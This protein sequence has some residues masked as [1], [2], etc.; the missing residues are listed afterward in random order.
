MKSGPS[1][2]RWSEASVSL[3]VIVALIGI[4]PT[5]KDCKFIGEVSETTG[6]CE[7]TPLLLLF[8]QPVIRTAR[9]KMGSKSFIS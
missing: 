2:L 3:S 8:L 6:G 9:I 5:G 4:C 7:S 1:I